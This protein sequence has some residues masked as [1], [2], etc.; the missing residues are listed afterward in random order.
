MQGIS[1]IHSFNLYFCEYQIFTHF[2]KPRTEKVKIFQQ[3]I[4]I[5]HALIPENTKYGRLSYYKKER[6]KGTQ[7]IFPF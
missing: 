4:L 1:V 7:K 5:L 3:S 2:C 6:E